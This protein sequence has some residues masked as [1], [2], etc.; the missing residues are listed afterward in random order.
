MT[1]DTHSSLLGRDLGLRRGGA[2]LFKGFNL[3]VHPRQALW[4]RGAN[5][6]GKTSLLR[7]A[8]GLARP[9]TGSFVYKG[10][11]VLGH[12]AFANAMVYIGHSYGLQDDLTAAEALGFLQRLHGRPGSRDA[13]ASAL[14]HFQVHPQRNT[15]LRL[16][17]QG[18]RKRVALAR[19]A[20]EAQGGL[21]VLDEP[22]DA[23]D[24]QGIAI[25]NALLRAH[26]GRGGSALLTSHTT[27]D[28]D[29]AE[30][31][32]LDLQKAWQP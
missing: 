8:T 19:L 22:F 24:T 25:V 27:V 11:P 30:V 17:S 2:W 9:D 7:L 5:G 14:E 1:S 23:L 6:C 13:I 31:R 32:A 16:L 21:W 4:L 18:Q 10:T 20:L 28:L 26:L 15:S 3:A 12:T 29:S